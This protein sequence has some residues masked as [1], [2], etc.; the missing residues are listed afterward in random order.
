MTMYLLRGRSVDGTVWRE[1]GGWTADRGYALKMS[2]E[3]AEVL[4][5][6][7]HELNRI[8][9]P[10]AVV[11]ALE[12]EPADQV[13]ASYAARLKCRSEARDPDRYSQFV[14]ED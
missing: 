1:Q 13:V 5:A 4:R 6:K 12:L 7:E 10:D 8:R 2:R 9:E 3:Q 14:R 11:G